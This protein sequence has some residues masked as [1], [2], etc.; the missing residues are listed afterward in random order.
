MAA[1][2]TSL[3]KAAQK[4]IPHMRDVI[5][6]GPSS[7]K[8]Q[9]TCKLHE[10]VK[11]DNGKDRLSKFSEVKFENS[12]HRVDVRGVGHIGQRIVAAFESV[13]EVVD[14]NLRKASNDIV[15]R[16]GGNKYID[17]LIFFIHT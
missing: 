14:L 9:L 11:V 12:G 15:A 13:T 1:L 8:S 10:L 16:K 2:L 17:S 6:D 7:L 3:Y 5:Y 4:C